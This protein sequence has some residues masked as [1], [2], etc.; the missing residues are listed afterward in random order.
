MS[1]GH[2]VGD[3]LAEN[4]K[5]LQTAKISTARLDCLVLLEDKTGKDR[6]W[7]L[8]HPEYLLSNAQLSTLEAQL[9][10]RSQH[11]PLAYIR[12]KAEFYGR[13]FKVTPHTLVPRPE[14]ESIIELL[15]QLRVPAGTRLID[16]GTGSGCIAVTVAL[17]MPVLNV[18]ASDI[19]V[20]CLNV[21]KQNA[22]MLNA[23]VAFHECNLLD[24]I[25]AGDILTANLPYVPDNFT[26]NTAATHE[27]RHALF[28]G[29]DGLDLYRELF[30]Q[31]HDRDAQPR[32]VLTE[33]LPPQHDD[34]ANIA[35]VFGY[36]YAVTKDFIQLF[37]A[38]S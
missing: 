25:D 10:R 12:G 33:S 9:S 16:V 32:Y 28:G 31:L 8:A 23:D 20:E 13:A 4:T 37:E 24:G 14:T 34:L 18:S 30:K 5:R 22:Q 17:E 2:N 15:K 3:F 1:Q 6:S 27:P 19:D 36:S 11:V 7:L 29:H 26:I 38:A 21:A 35:K